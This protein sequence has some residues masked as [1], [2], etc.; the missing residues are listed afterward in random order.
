MQIVNS[1]C[2]VKVSTK[3]TF[4]FQKVNFFSFWFFGFAF[5][6]CVKGKTKLSLLNKLDRGFG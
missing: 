4:T 1:L 5:V 6:V 2:I 3:A